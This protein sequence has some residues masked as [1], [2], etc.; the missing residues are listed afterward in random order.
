M[1]HLALAAILITSSAFAQGYGGYRD[2]GYR[3]DPYNRDA[4]AR[5]YNGSGAID[6][7]F[8]DLEQAA[9]STFYARH[10][11]GHIDH[12]LRELSKFQS[13]WSRGKF[14][15]HAL[16]EAIGEMSH[17][18]RSGEMHPRTREM[19]ARDADELR[20]FRAGAG[21]ESYGYGPGRRYDPYY[22]R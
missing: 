10:Q 13:K 19:L 5:G 18:A 2:G 7:A 6:R 1:R 17:I 14:D 22:G 4:Y 8:A 11:R 20:A 15:R 9:S 16:D 21:Y 12:A 3:G